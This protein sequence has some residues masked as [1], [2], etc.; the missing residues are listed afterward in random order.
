MTAIQFDHTTTDYQLSHA[1]NL[2]HAAKLAYSDQE[3]ARAQAEEWGFDRFAYFESTFTPPFALDH[4]QGFTMASDSMIVTAFRGTEVAQILDWL[5]DAKAPM[6]PH[7]SGRGMVHWGFHTALE[8]VYPRVLAAVEEFGTNGQSLWF[9]GHSLGGALAMLAAARVSL[10]DP[11]LRPA[12]VYT[13]GQPRTCDGLLAGAYD[14]AI[15]GRTYRFVNN[16]DIVPRVP[17]GPPYRHVAETR[18]FDSAGRLRDTEPS[19]LGGLT[20]KVR[21]HAAGI[22]SFK[23]GADGFTDHFIDAY[24][25]CLEAAAR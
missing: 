9:T 21:G 5:S 2:A 3:Q 17:A 7:S 10:D 23:P 24:I 20:D 12:G 16:N 22:A 11:R 19:L 25:D 1:L 18:Y 4:T 14:S 13:F 6:V 15:R 8:A